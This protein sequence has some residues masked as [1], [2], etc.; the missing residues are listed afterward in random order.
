MKGP[1]DRTK[2]VLRHLPPSISESNLVELIDSRFSGRYHWFAFCPGKSSQ[3]RLKYSRAYIGFYKPEDVIEFAAFFNGHAFV[4]EKGAQCK[5]IVEYAPSQRIPKK[6]FKKDGR[7]GT[8][9]KD[10]EY[11]DFLESLAK[12]IENLPSAEI[13]LERKEAER[14]GAPKDVPVVTPLMQYVR[15]KRA[16]KRNAVNGKLGRKVGGMPGKNVASGSSKRGS[17]RTSGNMYVLR[18]SSK[19]VSSSNEKSKEDDQSP[20]GKSIGSGLSENETLDEGNGSGPA[21]IEK[22]KILLLK[23]KELEIPQ[24][25]FIYFFQSMLLIM[26]RGSSNSKQSL[27]HEDGRRNIRSILLK[28]ET[29]Q[30]QP[31]SGSHFEQEPQNSTNPDIK[32]KSALPL[33]AVPKASDGA[34]PEKV[35]SNERL[36][37]PPEWYDRRSRNKDRPDRVVWTPH[38]ISEG[39]RAGDE[40]LSSSS[41][42]KSQVV[43]SEQGLRRETKYTRFGENR[44]A[45]SGRGSDIRGR[46]GA[47]GSPI[48]EGKSSKR[49]V[50]GYGSHEKQVW[51]QK[52]S[53]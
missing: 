48:V 8:I 42:Q 29:N 12:P 5:A 11:L 52:S 40:S 2:V 36:A 49:G 20:A 46:N 34:S 1:L 27:Q 33:Q 4:N 31:S 16:S 32:K 30:D 22:K 38:R 3:K 18:K 10:T 26:L 39:S 21:R 25:I 9:E 17:Q 50:S 35:I 43:D 44:S 14:A 23:G 7:E 19:S 53:S 45:G 51:V 47:D 37:A 24:V 41:S 15:Q 13:Q 28:R 6:P